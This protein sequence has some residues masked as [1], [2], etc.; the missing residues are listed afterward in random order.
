MCVFGVCVLL[1]EVV[2]AGWTEFGLDGG[3]RNKKGQ[4]LPEMRL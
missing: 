4:L 1:W 3:G 2:V